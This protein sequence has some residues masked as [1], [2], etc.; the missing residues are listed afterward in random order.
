[1]VHNFYKNILL[2]QETN[3]ETT[4]MR[5]EILTLSLNEQ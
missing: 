2:L 4:E 5:E 3:T 1:M